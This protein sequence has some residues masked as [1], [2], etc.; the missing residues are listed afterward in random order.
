[1]T[2]EQ[3]ILNWRRWDT[4]ISLS[5]QPTE[6]QLSTLAQSGVVQIINLGPHS[7]DGALDDEAA[8]VAQLGMEYVYI[9]VD[10]SNPTEADWTAFCAAIDAAPDAPLHVHCIYNA[11]V[12]A[13]FYRFAL[14]GRGGDVDMAFKLMDGI[15]RPG[16]VW[17]RFIGKPE[18]ADKSNRYL[19]YDYN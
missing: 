12:S 16:G 8:S 14:E 18:D 1:M 19:G 4:R 13:F 7:N 11:R 15:W 17:A 6:G 10:F 5:G 3:D 9:P 2:A